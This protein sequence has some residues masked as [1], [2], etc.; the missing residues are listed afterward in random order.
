MEELGIWS[1]EF[2][3][4]IVDNGGSCQGL[5]EVPKELQK[6]FVIASDII[7]KDHVS[8]VSVIQNKVDL[9][10]SKTCN[11]PNSAS[12]EDIMAVYMQAWEE[13]CKGI[14]VY[15]DGSR[16]DATLS[17]KREEAPISDTIFKPKSELSRGEIISPP[18]LSSSLRVKLNTGCGK[19]YLNISY[20][21]N[22][23]ITETFLN[24]GSDGGCT[25]FTQAT[26]RL[27]SLCLRGGISLDKVVDQLG[28]NP[29]CG[30][31]QK[32]RGAGKEVSKGKSCP[33][34]IGLVLLD[35]QK[36]IKA[37]KATSINPTMYGEIIAA[38][39][40]TTEG[41]CEVETPNEQEEIM[42]EELSDKKTLCPECN[43]KLNNEGG[44]IVCKFCGYSKCG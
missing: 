33:S 17:V 26:S 39:N 15:R 42:I 23:D 1:D 16:E 11:L 9:S 22:G 41:M 5:D 14:T 4:K 12:V 24:T 20:D 35:V 21:D 8:M 27:I 40:P 32:A 31:Y 37:L 25:I 2:A 28:S 44:C 36:K 3:Q 18:E 38:T 30:S 13:G 6:I 7:P 19:I 29:S 43:E 10:L 34:A